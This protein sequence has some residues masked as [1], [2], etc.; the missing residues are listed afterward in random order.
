MPNVTISLTL[1]KQLEK[2]ATGGKFKVQGVYDYKT[3][4]IDWDNKTATFEV[5][6]IVYELIKDDPEQSIKGAIIRMN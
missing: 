2:L 5:D 4:T 6:D 1:F 3:T